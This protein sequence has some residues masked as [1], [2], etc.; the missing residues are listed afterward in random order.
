LKRAKIIVDRILSICQNKTEISRDI[1]VVGE[2]TRTDMISL[3]YWAD[4]QHENY[5]YE[6]TMQQIL[7]LYHASAAYF[8]IADWLDDDKN[9]PGVYAEVEKGMKVG[10]KV[11]CNG[12]NFWVIQVQN[13]GPYGWVDENSVILRNGSGS[14]IANCKE[15]M[16]EAA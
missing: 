8:L 1:K 16:K 11:R 2:L 3:I 14:V 6:K 5:V 13:E 12:Y 4:R 10:D 9:A 15:I 7:D